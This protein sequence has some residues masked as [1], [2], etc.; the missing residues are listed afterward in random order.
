MF[1]GCVIS[2]ESLPNPSAAQVLVMRPPDSLEPR[3][4]ISKELT[5]PFVLSEVEKLGSKPQ[6]MASL[7]PE[8]GRVKDYR[9]NGGQPTIPTESKDGTKEKGRGVEARRE[10][11]RDR[12]KQGGRR[13]N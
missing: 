4:G 12:V 3:E 10:R 6:R 8:A 5:Q 7:H 11:R 1:Q 9:Q 2:P 13:R